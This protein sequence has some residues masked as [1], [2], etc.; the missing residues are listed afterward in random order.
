MTAQY[1][2]TQGLK[3]A[4]FSASD[5]EKGPCLTRWTTRSDSSFQQSE[6]QQDQSATH[7]HTLARSQ[8]GTLPS[9]SRLLEDGSVVEA[10]RG[11]FVCRFG[12]ITFKIAIL[13]SQIDFPIPPQFSFRFAQQDLPSDRAFCIMTDTW[14]KYVVVTEA[15][16]NKLQEG[17]SMDGQ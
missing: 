4:A 12:M 9:F 7:V 1:T 14:F 6:I 16:S 5:A 13:H 17:R 3:L 15:K 8:S 2:S 11:M 10:G